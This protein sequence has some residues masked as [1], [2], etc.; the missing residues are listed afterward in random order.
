MSSVSRESG[1]AQWVD[2]EEYVSVSEMPAER[3]ALLD[4][5]PGEPALVMRGMA[6]SEGGMT[7]HV[8]EAWY[9]R[10]CF[11]FSLTPGAGMEMR[12]P[13]SSADD[14]S[15]EWVPFWTGWSRVTEDAGPPDLTKTQ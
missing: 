7:V 9:K 2:S 12:A 5:V 1:R 11:R 8:F 10:G 14:A 15:A 4:M 3:A 13:G 6:R